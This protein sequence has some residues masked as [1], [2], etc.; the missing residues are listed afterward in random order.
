MISYWCGPLGAGWPTG[1]IPA[2]NGTLPSTSSRAFQ[3]CPFLTTSG[4]SSLP[5]KLS[6]I[7]T[8]KLQKVSAL[9][10]LGLVIAKLERDDIVREAEVLEQDG[11]LERVRA[12]AT[13][14]VEGELGS[15]H[16][17][18]L[19]DLCFGSV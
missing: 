10:T 13:V 14:R 1:A 19:L 2:H 6:K 8:V 17:G 11:D 18:G 5:L 16:F 9:D 15:G 3:L 4:R 12:R 7:L